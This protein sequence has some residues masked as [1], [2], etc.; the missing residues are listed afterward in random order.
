MKQLKSN[1]LL[2][3]I[4]DLIESTKF[5]TA[6]NINSDLVQ[7]YWEIGRRLHLEILE[8]QRAEYGKQV[9]STI[10][11]QLLIEYGKGFSQRNI[12]N[13]LR[14]A[15]TFPDKEILQTL[16]AQLSWSHIVEIIYVEDSLKR[17]F[18][19]QICRLERWSVRTLRKK[20]Q[21]MLFE[22]TAISKKPKELAIQELESLKNEDHLTPDLVLR[23]PYLLEFLRLDGEF[24]EKDLEDAILREL[25]KFI[26]EFGT[27]FSF[28]ARQKRLTIG[29]ED[30]YLDLLFFHR[31]LRKI[32]AIELK[33]G[34]FQ[35]A[36]KGQMELYLKWL[37][38]YEKKEGESEPLGIILCAE[39]N[40]EQVE[41]LEL[42]QSSIHVAEYLTQ[43]PSK[44]ALEAKLHQAIEVAQDRFDKAVTYRESEILISHLDIKKA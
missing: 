44:K 6:T 1:P 16:S 12:F 17:D 24:K 22:R 36:D 40:H 9:I 38:K 18:Y 43:L 37:N 28:L 29:N 20:M 10:S 32:I 2:N 19:A 14:F 39:K 42:G 31:S 5:K 33:L 7:L 21:G 4:R 27:D 3:E 35:A 34:K 11:N 25:E 30:F 23:D 41:L 26:L 8:D 15:Q 13:M